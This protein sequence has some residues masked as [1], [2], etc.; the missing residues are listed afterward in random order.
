MA[1]TTA[2]VR[3][4][5]GL[6]LDPT[7]TH[8]IAQGEPWGESR[9]WWI[10]LHAWSGREEV[11]G[12]YPTLRDARSELAAALGSTDA[13]QAAQSRSKARKPATQHDT[14]EAWL[15]AATDALRPAFDAINAPLPD[16]IRV[17]CGFPGGGSA[18]KRIGECWATSSAADKIN[19]VFISPVL[20]EPVND[21]GDG[22]LATLAHELVHVADDCKSGHKGAFRRIAVAL[23]LGGRMTA[24]HAG[25]ELAET[26]RG[27]AEELGPYPHAAVNLGL[28]VKKQTTRMRKVECDKTGYIARLTRKWLDEYGAP[29]CPCCDEQMVE[30]VEEV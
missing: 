18:R 5:A 20:A 26:L 7:E 19:N 23:G 11:L 24:T 16:T 13:A 2:V 29:Y 27:I 30:A 21:D 14:R 10:K 12:P 4:R 25:E 8:A 28:Q 3:V 6:Y 1:N 22:V 17:S 9:D 15:Q